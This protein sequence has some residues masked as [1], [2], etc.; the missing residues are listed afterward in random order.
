MVMNGKIIRQVQCLSIHFQ[1]GERPKMSSMFPDRFGISSHMTRNQ[2]LPQRL[3]FARYFIFPLA[4]LI[5]PRSMDPTEKKDLEQRIPCF[6]KV[7][8]MQKKEESPVRNKE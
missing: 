8:E 6:W 7:Q 4:R 3:F 5:L 1:K 2:K